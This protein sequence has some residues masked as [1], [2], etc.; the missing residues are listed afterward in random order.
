MAGEVV[1]TYPSQPQAAVQPSPPA[2]EQASPAKQPEKPKELA[3]TAEQTRWRHFYEWQQ[4]VDVQLK[5]YRDWITR[6]LIIAML[7]AA[8]AACAGVAVIIKLWR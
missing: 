8:A 5:E 3:E 7:S 1:V 2:A 6:A 4:W